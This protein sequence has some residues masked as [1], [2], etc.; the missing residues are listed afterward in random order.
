[1][2]SVFDWLILG[3]GALRYCEI[4]KVPARNYQTLYWLLVASSFFKFEK[5]TGKMPRFLET[6]YFVLLLIVS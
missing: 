2:R 4:N 1:M 5:S 6:Y 3:L